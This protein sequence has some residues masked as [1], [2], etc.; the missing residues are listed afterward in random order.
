MNILTT[1]MSSFFGEKLKHKVNKKH[2][3]LNICREFK[4]TENKNLSQIKFSDRDLKQK[5]EAFKPEIF[6]N[7]ASFSRSEENTL[8]DYKLISD[9]NIST[10]IFL[11]DLLV[12]LGI[13]LIINISSNWAYL[14]G[15]ENKKFF[16]Y[17][18]FSK[19]ALDQY[20]NSISF[21][22]KFRSI[23]LILY[24]NF[25][26]LDPRNKIFN[27]VLHALKNNIKIDLSP[28]K[29]ILNLTRADDVVEA[30]EFSL[31]NE[32]DHIGHK[33]Y[34]LTGQEINLY[35][36]AKK[37]SNKKNYLISNLNFGGRPYRENEIMRHLYFFEELPFVGKRKES[38]DMLLEKE[39]N[40]IK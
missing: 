14:N 21:Q 28:C 16:N 26:S 6:L 17:Y 20:I 2:K 24:D 35:D 19:F 40:K 7:M 4:D 23:S 29:Q 36:L 22:N 31:N 10:S 11:C 30:I 32:W 9:F 39:L 34:Q 27:I 8:E 12:E 38:F 1:G 3:I 33:Y 37:I 25:D 15:L 5:I 18:S 13:K